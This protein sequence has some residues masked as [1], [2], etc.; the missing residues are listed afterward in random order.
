MADKTLGN[1]EAVKA[2]RTRTPD[3]PSPAKETATA[4]RAKTPETPEPKPEKKAE[5]VDEFAERL[6]KGIPGI[7]DEAIEALRKDFVK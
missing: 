3:K 6:R 2:A 4:A 5:P 7:S 1:S